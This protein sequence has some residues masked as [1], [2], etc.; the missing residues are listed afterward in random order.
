[1][2]L[3]FRVGKIFCKDLF[4]IIYA[5]LF[6]RFCFGKIT[7]LNLGLRIGKFHDGNFLNIIDFFHMA[8]K[9]IFIEI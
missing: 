9:N 5:Y 4:N 1:M 7:N 6:F 3:R 2:N 8:Q